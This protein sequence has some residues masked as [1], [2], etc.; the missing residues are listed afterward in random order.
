[1]ELAA[2]WRA[3]LNRK[4]AAA[5]PVWGS[6]HWTLLILEREDVTKDDWRVEYKDSLE[7]LSLPCADNAKKLLEILS[8]ATGKDLSL[9]PRANK[10]RQEKMSGTC[11]FFVGHWIDAKMREVYRN[12]PKMGTGNPMIAPMKKD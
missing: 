8:A 3:K 12:E 4:M 10:C 11:G 1:M 7:N 6:D 2:Q 5:I 9:P